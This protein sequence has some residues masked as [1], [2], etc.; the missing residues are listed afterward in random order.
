MKKTFIGLTGLLLM[1]AGQAWAA[2]EPSTI[3]DEMVVSATST[4]TTLD[5]IGGS[6]VTVITA[7]DIEAKN[8]N[9]VE[10]AIKGVPGIDIVANGGP[11]TKTSVF[12][13]GADSKDTLVLIDGIMV[14]DPSSAGRSCDLGSIN[15]DNVERIEVVRGA[16]SVMYGSNAT[17]GVINIITKKGAK[18]PAVTFKAEAGSYGT[19]KT[20]GSLSGRTGDLNYSLSASH[21]EIDGFSIANDDNDK[22]AH[23]GNTDEDDGYENSSFSGNLGY[24]VTDDFSI[25]AVTRYVDT[26]TDIDEFGP[27]HIGDNFTPGATWSDPAT[28]NPEGPTQKKIEKEQALAKVTLKNSFSEKFFIST[29]SYQLSNINRKAYNND[30]TLDYRYNGDSKELAWQ[31]DLNFDSNTLSF[32]TSLFEEKMEN[33]AAYGGIEEKKAETK[34]C[35]L[36]DQFFLGESL[37]VVGGVRLDDHE[38]FGSKATWRVAPSYTIR[39]TNTVLKASYGTGFRAPSLYELY[40]DYGNQNLDAEESK[41]W[42][43]GFEQSLMDN[44]VRFGVTYFAMD[45]DN[46]IGFDMTT[47][48]YSQLDGK[49]ETSGVEAFAGWS[50][51]ANLDFMLNYTYTETNDPDDKR[52]LRRPYNKVSL[53]TRYSFLDKGTVNLDIHWVDDRKDNGTDKNG[54]AVTD[55]AAYTLVNL[56]ASYELTKNVELYGRIDNLFDEFYEEAFSYATPGLSGYLGL[57]LTF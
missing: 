20:L 5:K 35:W 37:V 52:L 50:P 40:S 10:E 29:F 21:T 39:A 42:D 32:G 47:W 48:K 24:D 36:Q 41:G 13:R 45:Y 54:N 33:K 34:S 38:N 19:W 1:V 9:S 57:K 22:I 23:E 53:N 26:T 17:A 7:Q 31:G 55:L 14:N 30:G 28:P 16:M 51:L 12:T 18:K 49:T 4:E 56:A 44:A 25:S 6:S 3:M 43:V 2:G 11:G 8:L 15:L 46:R 27:Y